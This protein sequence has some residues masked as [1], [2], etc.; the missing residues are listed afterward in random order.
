VINVDSSDENSDWIQS[1]RDSAKCEKADN[2][3]KDPV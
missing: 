3:R 1:V 2:G